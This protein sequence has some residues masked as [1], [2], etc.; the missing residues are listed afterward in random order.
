MLLADLVLELL[1]QRQ[2]E[3]YDFAAAQAYQMLMFGRRSCLVMMMFFDKVIFGY[4]SQLLK[5]LQIAIDSGQAQPVV[6]F[7]CLTVEL[8]SIKMSVA[9]ADEVKQQRPLIGHSLT[10]ASQ[11]LLTGLFAQKPGCHLFSIYLY[12]MQMQIVCI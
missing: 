4:Q 8:I 12:K 7:V 1:A 9:L 5:K 3:L 10:G 11:Y 6:L 2:V